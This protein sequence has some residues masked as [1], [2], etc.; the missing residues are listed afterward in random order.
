MKSAAMKP[1]MAMVLCAV[2]LVLIIPT[3]KLLASK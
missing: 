3:R 2:M 1:A